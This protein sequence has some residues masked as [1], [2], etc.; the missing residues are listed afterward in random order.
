MRVTKKNPE[1]TGVFQPIIIELKFDKEEEVRQY[2][3]ALFD[4]TA[5]ARTEW[6][7]PDLA[8]CTNKLYYMLEEHLLHTCNI[9]R[10]PK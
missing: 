10:S 5:I 4:I 6:T 2:L 1:S 9:P 7:P 3:A 8:S